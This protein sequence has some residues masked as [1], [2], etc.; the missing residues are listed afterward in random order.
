MSKNHKVPRL[1]RKWKSFDSFEVAAVFEAYPA[2]IRMRL[3]DLRQLVFDTART[4]SGVGELEETLRWGEPSYLTTGSRSGS[5]IRID[6]RNPE[7]Y[8][9]Y[10][11]CQTDLIDRFKQRY[12]TEFEYDGNRS[13]VFEKNTK[14][15][16]AELSQCIAQALTYHL[17]KEK[18]K[19][20][21]RSE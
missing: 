11:H 20:S 8:A 7:E 19:G 9:I 1:R 18:R 12:P 16:R 14:I 17:D 4:T 13:I 2:E 21:R 15:P 10:F 6:S 3:M 5:I